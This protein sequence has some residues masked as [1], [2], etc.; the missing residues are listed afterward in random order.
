MRRMMKGE[1]KT[2]KILTAQIFFLLLCFVILPGTLY[3][4]GR[5]YFTKQRI[6]ELNW[7]L[8]LPDNMKCL[9]DSHTPPAFHG[10]GIRHT[11]FRLEPEQMTIQMN[12]GRNRDVEAFCT[13][14]CDELETDANDL[15]DF[16]ERYGWIKYEKQ[17]D[18]LI[19]VYFP[20]LK[21]L[22]F[23]QEIF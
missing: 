10:E 2:A 11:I 22:H 23:F 19:I 21:Q 13:A 5:S 9:Y 4:I 1:K 8:S 16:E 15:P 7:E 18:T 14:I 12:A 20:H 6:Y 3:L 17:Q